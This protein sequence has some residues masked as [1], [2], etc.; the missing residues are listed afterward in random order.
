MKITRK[1]KTKSE[2]ST[3]SLPDII[4]MLLIFFMVTTVLKKYDGLQ[5]TIPSAEQIEQFEDKRNI[6]YIWLEKNGTVVVDEVLLKNIS[7]VSGIIKTKLTKSVDPGKMIIQFKADYD[8]NFEKIEQIH[9]ECRKANALK[10]SYGA[11]VLTSN[12][13]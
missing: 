2:I 1:N 5:T 9:T 13:N 10:I 4:F 11:L 6:I 12:K 7:E 8:T 3:S